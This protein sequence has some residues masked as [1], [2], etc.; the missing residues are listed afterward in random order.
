M[1]HRGSAHLGA[2]NRGVARLTR[3]ARL[4]VQHEALP[5]EVLERVLAEFLGPLPPGIERQA[6]LKDL[7][8]P[9]SARPRGGARAGEWGFVR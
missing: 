7:L 3:L 1:K 6:Y 9:P 8:L 4:V 2:A 5:L